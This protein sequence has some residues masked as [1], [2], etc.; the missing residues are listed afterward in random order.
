MIRITDGGSPTV[1]RALTGNLTGDLSR[2]RMPDAVLGD[3]IAVRPGGLLSRGLTDPKYS[4]CPVGP[5][6]LRS[7]DL[8]RPGNYLS[9]LS[10][11]GR[12]P[13]KE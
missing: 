2:G 9:L 8:N 5:P 3:M 13:V 11:R 6:A 1:L 10:S 7:L 12:P 4:P